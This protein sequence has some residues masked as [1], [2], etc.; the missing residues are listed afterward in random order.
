MLVLRGH[1]C[2]RGDTYVTLAEKRRHA[3]DTGH[4]G[5]KGG[6]GGLLPIG[7]RASLYT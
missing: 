3:L 7:V 6:E 5:W 4:R 2:V 1:S